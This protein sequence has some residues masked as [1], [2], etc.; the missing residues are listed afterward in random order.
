MTTTIDGSEYIEQA[1]QL[2]SRA[3]VEELILKLAQE[4]KYLKLPFEQIYVAPAIWFWAMAD[5]FSIGTWDDFVRVPISL[6]TAK[7]LCQMFG[8]TLP[9]SKM[10]DLI[11]RQ[12]DAKLPPMPMGPPKYPYDESMMSVQRYVVHNGWVQ[13]RLRRL[14]LYTKD[15]LVA[16]HKKDIVI[17]KKLTSKSG[18]LGL[19]GW[20]RL[21]GQPIQGPNVSVRHIET[22]YDYSH[23]FRP[24]LSRMMCEGREMDVLDV[25]S[26]SH[27]CCH[28]SS[29]GS[30]YVP[31]YIQPK[32]DGKYDEDEPDT[33]RESG[34][35]QSPSVSYP[36]TIPF[37]Q[38]RNYRYERLG[39]K[40]RIKC[41]VIHTME[42]AE[43]PNT[44]ENCATW[45]AGPH[46][47]RA[48]CHFCVD[49]NSIVQCVKEKDTAWHAP[50]VNHCSIG[51][52]HAG[53]AKQEAPE[54]DDEY[55]RNMLTLSAML[56]ARLCKRYG[57]PIKFATAEDLKRN[58]VGITYHS[59]VSDA[60]KRSNHYD[61]G[62][63]FPLEKYLESVRRYA[64]ELD[65]D[66]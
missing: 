16:G 36:H 37:R 45:F 10:V 1:R 49:E 40:P 50:G 23:G 61:P 31:D 60:F 44:A 25:L 34:F 13:K 28:I 38:A 54:W 5:Y 2:G 19:Y 41:I 42:A 65:G 33:L 66:E 43:H 17:T 26:C 48:S 55:S 62:K 22:Y 20:H 51:I 24:C 3:E 57:I 7:K 30:L 6:P 27:L 56:V 9:T 47:P 46:A 39:S 35:F 32:R 18:R 59:C 64:A 58:P 53:Y 21:D 8:W 4:G 63:H 14:T 12:A 11:W 29:E 52:E 15:T